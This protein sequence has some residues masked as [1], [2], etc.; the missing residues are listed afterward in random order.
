MTNRGGFLNRVRRVRIGREEN[1][2][3]ALP[4]FR[5]IRHV[6]RGDVH[7]HPA[8][9]RADNPAHQHRPRVG[10]AAVN[11]FV[12]PG[13]DAANQHLSRRFKSRVVPDFF[14]FADPFDGAQDAPQLEGWAQGH[15][16]ARI[17][18]DPVNPDPDARG[19]RLDFRG[20]AK[21]FS[22]GQVK[23]P[24]VR[25]GFLEL[26]RAFI[27]HFDLRLREALVGVFRVSQVRTDPL[28]NQIAVTLKDRERLRDFGRLDPLPVHARVNLEV[29]RLRPAQG[30]GNVAKRLNVG[31]GECNAAER[32]AGDYF[33]T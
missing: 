22:R 16:V 11:P 21:T 5:Q 30:S 20:P 3:L 33:R 28:H 25:Q 2:F 15:A 10:K 8:D 9:D 14:S 26:L 6:N 1:D 17:R 7:T 29:N 32:F 31:D 13:R 27:P 23:V 19:I 12:V 18:V 4:R 24:R